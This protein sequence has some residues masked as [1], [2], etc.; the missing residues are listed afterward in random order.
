MGCFGITKSWTGLSHRGNAQ[1]A[2]LPERNFRRRPGED[3]ITVCKKNMKKKWKEWW[4]SIYIV[5]ILVLSLYEICNLCS[6][7]DLYIVSHS[8]LMLLFQNPNTVGGSKYYLY[9]FSI[10]YYS[11]LWL[12]IF[13]KYIFLFIF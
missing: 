8:R 2:V 5:P 10:S 13:K 3:I 11:D 1:L 7:S 6:Y 9:S 4:N 12:K